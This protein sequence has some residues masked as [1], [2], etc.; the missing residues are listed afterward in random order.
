VRAPFSRTLFDLLREQAERRPAALAAVSRGAEL[1][2]A[3]LLSRARRIAGALRQRDVVRGDR[4]G[5]V[6]GNRTEWLELA[7][8]CS[9]VGATFV[10][11]STWSTR[12]ELE[13]LIADAGVTQ[14]F[15]Y[16]KYGERDFAEDLASLAP[17][18][19]SGSRSSRFPQLREIV[20]IDSGP[21]GPFVHYE[22]FISASRDFSDLPPGEAS[23]P[24][25]DALILYTSGSSAHPKA[26]RLKHFGMIENGFNIGERMRLSGDDRVMLSAPLF[27][28]YGSA[29]AMCAAVSHGAALVLQE[30]FEPAGAIALIE[31]FACTAIYTLPGMTKAI[32]T[33]PTFNRSRVATLRTGLTIGA[34]S[35]F[36]YAVEA[37]GA[38][39]LCNIYG[40]TETYGNCCVT[41]A[42]W[43]IDRRA[44]CQGEP[45]PGNELRFVDP[46]TGEP[47]ARG[48][49]G[50]VEVRGYI[51]PGYCGTSADQNAKAFTPDGYYRTGDVGRL[52]ERGAFVFVARNAEMIKRAGI[53]VSP[54]EVEN[55][56]LAHPQVAQA[57]VVGAADA[58]RGE[59]IVAFV[60]P[61]DP[62][63]SAE[64][65]IAHC[66]SV[67]SKYKVPDRI[68][69][70]GALPL[71]STGKLQRRALK[72][73]AQEILESAAG[74]TNV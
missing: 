54:A 19:T 46:E 4:I 15:A 22:E 30:R 42:A 2:Y 39:R 59:A 56:L 44:N 14:F 13:F 37:L 29:N 58:D 52:D 65:L 62:S 70:Q 61:V 66:R 43:S 12:G 17:E 5:A 40:A 49:P 7:F 18:L 73:T 23:G 55:I 11:M 60:V 51:S 63:L 25:D 9:A 33:H 8:G 64:E 27:W 34:P 67:A 16:A 50:L 31:S 47:T 35:E 3:D 24:D 69:L 10:P 1:S 71:T 28:S 41:S 32:A 38:E 57:A 36:R 26:V 21:A 74:G 53:N 45:L 6:L 68:V 72:E 48:E 20:L